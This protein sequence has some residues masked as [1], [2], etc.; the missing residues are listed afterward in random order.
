MSQQT[1]LGV[2]T[3]L[4]SS[5]IGVVIQQG[6]EQRSPFYGT[7]KNT[8]GVPHSGCLKHIHEKVTQVIEEF[9]PDAVAIEGI[10]HCKNMQ[11]AFALGQAR[12]A[13]IAA[14]ALKEV[15][16]YE[17][18]PRLVKK[19]IVGTGKAQKN[20]VALMVQRMLALD[21]MPKDDPADALAI[22]LCHLHQF[23][24]PEVSGIKPI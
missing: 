15:P 21:A 12:G 17:Y 10:F 18:A 11:V 9:Q 22:A 14:A 5:G 4:R 1:I 19:G 2:D 7:I 23:R 3:S 20:Q 6:Q 16:V 13:V 8:K 24:N